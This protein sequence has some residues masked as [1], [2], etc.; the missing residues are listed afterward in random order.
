MKNILEQGE[1][2]TPNLTPY[3][4]LRAS[5]AGKSIYFAVKDEKI[6]CIW[7]FSKE[8][9]RKKFTKWTII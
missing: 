5:Q 4:M 8:D 9:A 1:R 2:F 7:A 6:R 3:Q